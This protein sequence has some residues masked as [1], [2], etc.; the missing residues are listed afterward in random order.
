MM[1]SLSLLLTNYAITKYH[2]IYRSAETFQQFL[3]NLELKRS[4]ENPCE[5]TWCILIHI[6]LIYNQTLSIVCIN[7]TVQ[8]MSFVNSKGS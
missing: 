6:L 1:T 7:T 8:E 5:S 4:P 3:S 2:N